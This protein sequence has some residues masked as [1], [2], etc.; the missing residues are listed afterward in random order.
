AKRGN[1]PVSPSG[2]SRTNW[3]VEPSRRI[4]KLGNSPKTSPRCANWAVCESC[5]QLFAPHR[6]GAGEPEAIVLAQELPADLL[7]VDERQ[8]REK[9]RRLGIRVTGA[10]GV[11]TEAKRQGLLPA[12]KPVIEDLRN[13]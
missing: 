5:L 12:A 8:T 3:V 2:N 4:M 7:I 10:L 6:V 9:A 1:S 11:L 13:I